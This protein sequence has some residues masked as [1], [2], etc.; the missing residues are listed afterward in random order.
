[1]GDGIGGGGVDRAI[2]SQDDGDAIQGKHQHVAPHGNKWL[3]D[4]PV[5]RSGDHGVRG[6]VV[7]GSRWWLAN[8]SSLTGHDDAIGNST[9]PDAPNVLAYLVIIPFISS[10]LFAG[11]KNTTSTSPFLDRKVPSGS[12]LGFGGST[13]TKRAPGGWL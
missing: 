6:V 8:R 4:A 10:F 3:V 12:T 9:S 2:I 11:T 13:F 1:M 5:S 7:K